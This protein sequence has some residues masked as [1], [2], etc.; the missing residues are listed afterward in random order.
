MCCKLLAL[1]ALRSVAHEMFT[2][3]TVHFGLW[4]TRLL[5]ICI[6]LSRLYAFTSVVAYWH[7]LTAA[8]CS[9]TVGYPADSA[10]LLDAEREVYMLNKRCG[11]IHFIPL[12][13][14]M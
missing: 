3:Q 13:V 1:S 5:G 14:F 10:S 9:R 12:N 11:E 8:A 7:A 6:I 2:A 4:D